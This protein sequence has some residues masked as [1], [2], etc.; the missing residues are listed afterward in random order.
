MQTQNFAI[1]KFRDLKIN[2][3]VSDFGKSQNREISK[4]GNRF[5]LGSLQ[6]QTNYE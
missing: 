6:A 2:R 1:L 4:S 3:E 5:V